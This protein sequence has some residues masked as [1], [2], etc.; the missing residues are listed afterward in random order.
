[1]RE[2]GRRDEDA[3]EPRQFE[4]LFVARDEAGRLARQL[5]GD[6]RSHLFARLRPHVAQPHDLDAAGRGGDRFVEQVGA[7]AAAADE[8]DAHAIVG[9]E[10]GVWRRDRGGSEAGAGDEELTTVER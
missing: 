7:A 10:D 1:M 4:Q 3:V 8:A 9:A 6:R 5:L 2:V